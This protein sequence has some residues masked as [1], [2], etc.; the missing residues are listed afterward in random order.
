MKKGY[1]LLILIIV[2]IIYLSLTVNSAFVIN[3]RDKYISAYKNNNLLRLHVLGNSNTPQDQFIKRKIRD[4]VVKNLKI[5]KKNFKKNELVIKVKHIIN[6]KLQNEGVD[7]KAKVEIGKYLFPKRTYANLTLPGGYYN[8]LKIELG[9]GEGS[10]WWCVLFPPLCLDTK[11]NKIKNKAN[12][13]NGSELNEVNKINLK[14]KFAE[15][16]NLDT[17][18]DF[19][20]NILRRTRR[21]ENL[22]LLKLYAL[23]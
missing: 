1:I 3:N 16:L 18:K 17:L 11:T 21:I 19:E 9:K 10:N 4:Q 22:E 6:E 15:L 5:N 8:A 12:Q 14:F 23:N 13:I 20:L 2:S 7:Y